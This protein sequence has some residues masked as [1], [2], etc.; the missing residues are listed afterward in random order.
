MKALAVLAIKGGVGKTLISTG[1]ARALARNNKVV[2]LDAD[3]DSANAASILGTEGK[4]KITED[5]KVEPVMTE[6]GVLVY[7]METVWADS[8]L[9]L[10]ESATKGLLN[11]MVSMA[12]KQNPDYIIIDSPAGASAVFRGMLDILSANDIPRSSVVVSE[13]NVIKDLARM[14]KICNHGFMPIQGFVENKSGCMVG[15]EIVKTVEERL[16]TPHGKGGV[17]KYAE[18]MG[19][20][21]LTT[22]PLTSQREKLDLSYEAGKE[23]AEKL[24]D[25]MY[26]N[27]D[28]TIDESFIRNLVLL[29][30]ETV[31][32]INNRLPIAQ[33]QKRY[34]V[35]GGGGLVT[36]LELKDARGLAKRMGLG[37]INLMTKDG[38]IKL[39]RNPEEVAGGVRI[40][41]K[42]L[43]DG[44]RMKK[45]ALDSV[46]GEYTEIPYSLTEAVRLGFAEI[47][48][49]PHAEVKVD[50]WTMMMVLD[51]IM[52]DYIGE[53]ELKGLAEELDII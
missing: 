44:L 20:K 25:D 30:K 4:A 12:I 37:K 31:K 26:I 8:T 27:P 16:F 11:T 29:I 21:L 1:I 14:V 39:I 2:L 36:Q 6:D 13:P 24:D 45:E 35:I 48:E 42:E 53:D 38:Q 40:D 33:L 51:Y 5:H 46:K 10:T 43:R 50:S 17:Y 47:W 18:R 19:G 9:S 32:I 22:L 34:G 3:I 52:R 49:N 15:G 28:V 7:S 23:I 41:A